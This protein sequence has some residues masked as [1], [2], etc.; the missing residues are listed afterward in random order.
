M[1]KQTKKFQRNL[2]RDR[3]AHV[4]VTQSCKIMHHAVCYMIFVKSFTALLTALF[5][6]EIVE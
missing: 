5:H 4:L 1:L 2:E 3:V 6:I